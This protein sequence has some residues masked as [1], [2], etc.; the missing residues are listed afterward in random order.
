MALDNNNNTFTAPLGQQNSVDGLAGSDTLVINWSA[1]TGAIRWYDAG[2]GWQGFSDGAYSSVDYINFEIFQITGGNQADD[3]RGGNN[4]DILNGGAGDDTLYS[5]LGND[6]LDGGADL[7]RWVV[8][9]S[10]LTSPISVKL[11]TGGAAHTVAATGLSVKNV[12]ALN[13]TTGV[14]DDTINT[15]LMTGNDVISTGSGNDS[16]L[17]GLGFDSINGGEGTD[18][19]TLNFSTQGE[20]I[21]RYDIGYGWMRYQVGDEVLA[22]T[23]YNGIERFS[24][25]GGTGNDNL[26]GGALNDVLIGNAGND[27][28]DGNDGVDQITGG[29]GTD[30]WV[31][32]YSGGA[33]AALNI[34]VNLNSVADVTTGFQSASTGAKFKEIERLNATSGIGNDTITALPGIF[35]DVI[36]TGNG[37]DVASLGRGRDTFEAGDNTTTGDQMILNWSATTSNISWADTGYG[38]NRYTSLEG[39]QVDFVGVERFVLTG[40][41]GNDDLRG[42]A[43]TDT[44][45]GGGGNDWLRS[46]TGNATIDGGVGT[47][48]WQADMSACLASISISASASQTVAQ[49]GAGTG[50]SIL[51]IEGLS[52]FT[53]AG[54]DVL[55]TYGYMTDDTVETRGG[56]DTVNLGLGVNRV[57]GGDGEDT[58][59]VNYGALTSAVTRIDEGYGW[60]GYYDKFGTTSTSFIN[61]DKFNITGGSASDTLVGGALADV[62]QG[63]IGNDTLRGGAGSDTIVGGAGNDRWVADYSGLI[64]GLSLTLNSSGIGTLVG[65]GTTL[66]GIE[67]ITLTTS[68]SAMTDTIDT[69]AIKGNDTITT[70]AGNDTVRVGAGNH[71]LSG[72]EGNDLLQFNFSTSV[73]SI[74]GQDMGY[75]WYKYSDSAGLNS[76]NFI[77]FES[78]RITGGSGADRLSSWGGD[79]V[80]NGGAGDDVINGGGGNDSLTGGLGNDVFVCS[81]GNGVDLIYDAAAGDSIRVGVTLSGAVTT[82]NGSAVTTGQVQ[83]SYNATTL[84]TSLFVG[85]DSTPGADLTISLN[86]N[87]APSVFT[88]SGQNIKLNGSSTGS[89][90]NDTMIGSSGNDTLSGG[91]GDDTLTGLGGNDTLLGGDGTDVLI[92]GLGTDTLNGGTGAD[93]FRY[94]DPS[95]STAGTAYHDIIQ[96]FSTAQGDKIDLSPIDTKPFLVN[97]QAF[98]FI[99]T[100]F[101]GTDGQV[102]FYVDADLGQGIVSADINGD[103]IAD[104]EIALVGVTSMAQTDFIL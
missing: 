29:P 103:A 23:D 91:L 73:G 47:D 37:D 68:S 22:Q 54:N 53:G 35:N 25:T 89:T 82:G 36:K 80:I 77:G 65:A 5:G 43:S 16:I 88:L 38:W 10:S 4:G 9:Y 90:A 32:N 48:I 6:N 64:A 58:L 81:V 52:L 78:F 62:L 50:L 59:V 74:L 55:N 76:A 104:I 69:S 79:D 101:T 46:S 95:D 2:Y 75:G 26:Y 34:V 40:G 56:N 8:D 7:D 39:D 1:A 27:N 71:T 97:D 49:G 61:F 28:L 21:N 44:L 20:D 42:G 83:C 92:G 18:V 102:R 31:F 86:G 98:T 70:Q 3:L 33:S 45:V 15:S 51:G 14:G 30:T 19:L 99:T 84:K 72:G 24:L 12:E 94:V 63:G 67:N 96:D 87:Y 17:S 41:S 57:N 93:I 66:N 85:A 11:L 13:I 60:F 100:N